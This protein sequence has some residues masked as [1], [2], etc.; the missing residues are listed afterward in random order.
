LPERDL[1]GRA[2]ELNE[3]RITAE[4]K[5]IEFHLQDSAL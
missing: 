3:A 2:T 5:Q 1:V 4:S